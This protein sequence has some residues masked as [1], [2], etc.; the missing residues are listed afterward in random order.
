[1]NLP[2]L[3]TLSGLKKRAEQ[4]TAYHLPGEFFGTIERGIRKIGEGL[5]DATAIPETRQKMQQGKSLIQAYGEVWDEARQEEK[6][7]SERVQVELEGARSAGAS[8]WE[9][10]KIESKD[11]RYK[12]MIDTAMGFSGG[13]KIVRPEDI[14]STIGKLNYAIREAKPVREA[15]EELYTAARSTRAA[16]G[17]EALKSVGGEKG[18]IEALKKL[19]GKLPKKPF[20]AIKKEFTQGEVDDLFNYIKQTEGFG[21][22]EKIGTSNALVKL[23]EGDVPAR[24]ELKLLQKAFGKEIVE[25]VMSRRSLWEKL[26]EG[27]TELMNLPRALTT[28]FDMSAPLRQGIVLGIHKPKQ[29]I[30]AAKD[31]VKYFFKPDF[32]ETAMD[33]IARMPNYD[34][35]KKSKLALTETGEYAIGLVEREEA[36]MTNLAEHI[37][38]VGKAVAASERA[39]VGFLNKLRAD[40]FDDLAQEF[41]K[42]GYTPKT[43]P[44][45]YGSLADFINTATGRGGGKILEKYGPT[46]NTVFFSPRFQAS[47]VQMLNPMWYAKQHP[48]VRKE[49]AKSFIKFVSTGIGALGLAKLGGAEVESDPRSADFGKIKIGNVRWDVWG[50]FQ[51]WTRFISQMIL[52]EVKSSKSGNVWKLG[53]ETF[54]FK[55]RVDWATQFVE[56]KLAPVPSLV[57]ELLRGSSMMGEEITLERTA[58]DKFIPFYLQGLV[59]AYGEMGWSAIPS[60]GVPSFFGVGVQVYDSSSTKKSGATPSLPQ[61]PKLPKLPKL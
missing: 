46:L 40:V 23:F 24:G 43:N 54:P 35:M 19:K 6:I 11:P 47:R 42:G 53:G 56:S 49:A 10:A 34:L 12:R 13:I 7:E 48:V 3:P 21:F 33:D 57:D 37:P 55:D 58:Y 15:T 51:Q 61:L 60:V 4:T 25:S 9:L 30:S 16:K 29:A 17:A 31:M 38:F 1:M 18:Y 28:S 36:Y 44:Q 50:G 20:E 45:V 41:M 27:L 52:G 8:S 14:V 22:W 2:S 59:E 26:G 5:Y 32:Y 39:Y